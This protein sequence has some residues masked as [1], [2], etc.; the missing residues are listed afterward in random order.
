M[1]TTA[2]RITRTAGGN[3]TAPKCAPAPSGGYYLVSTEDQYSPTHIDFARISSSGTIAWQKLLS[4]PGDPSITFDIVSSPTHVALRFEYEDTGTFEINTEVLLYDSDGTL[5]WRSVVGLMTAAANFTFALAPSTNH[6]YVSGQVA[7]DESMLV[8][9]DGADG[10]VDW[11]INLRASGETSSTYAAGALRILSGGDLVLWGRGPIHT[12]ASAR[13]YIQRCSATDGSVVWSRSVAWPLSGLSFTGMAVDASDNIYVWGREFFDPTYAQ[14]PV[15][16]FDSSGNTLWNRQL[17]SPVALQSRSLNFNWTSYG[18]AGTNGLLIPN[19]YGQDAVDSGFKTG[20]VFIPAAGSIA[21]GNAVLSTYV[22]EAGTA[23][24]PT[25]S[26]GTG[27]Q[28]VFAYPDTDLDTFEEVVILFSSAGTAADDAAFDTQLRASY[29]YDTEA[30]TATVATATYT[31]ASNITVTTATPPTL[32][33][34]AGTLTA[35]SLTGAA[36]TQT[37]TATGL[38]STLAFGLPG[39]LGLVTGRASTLAFGTATNGRAQP[40]TGRASTLAFGST[41]SA[42]KYNATGFAQTNAFGAPAANLNLSYAAAAIAPTAQFGETWAWLSPPAP[43]RVATG[44]SFA[45]TFGTPAAVAARAATATGVSTT[46]IPQPTVGLGLSA[47]GAPSAAA[48]GAAKLSTPGRAAG[49]SATSFGLPRLGSNSVAAALVLTTR[50]G[51]P[52]ALAP[53]GCLAT[54]FS[55]SVFGTPSVLG[56]RQ[57]ARSGV[58]RTTFGRARAERTSP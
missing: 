54:G 52:I 36:P 33:S 5:V 38:A 7:Y 13:T 57:N 12:D 41:A 18:F 44:G 30:G 34:A 20:H 9:L 17:Q 27:D 24:F 48:F 2:L 31:R 45:P 21:S 28:I 22:N 53:N 8:K 14:L 46:V 50:F 55:A 26:G 35:T 1:T 40:A 58:F 23:P 19:Y 6:V 43:P 16:K 3:V 49:L 29:T 51:L 47:T 11:E 37:G 15:V 42:Q 32:T 25:T 10:S 39:L 56:S 4:L